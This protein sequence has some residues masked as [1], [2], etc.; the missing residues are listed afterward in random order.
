MSSTDAEL[1]LTG[2]LCFERSGPG[3]LR[4]PGFASVAASAGLQATSWVAC[5]D[6]VSVTDTYVATGTRT[7]LYCLSA[8]GVAAATGAAGAGVACRGAVCK[9]R[10][11]SE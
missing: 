5:P 3:C 8:A 10:A 6:L 7:A 11:R 9:H 2:L 1:S 4:S